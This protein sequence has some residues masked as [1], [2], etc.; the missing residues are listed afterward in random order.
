M[1]MHA[2]IPPSK[3]FVALL[4]TNLSRR[5]RLN[6]VD[7]LNVTASTARTSCERLAVWNIT[8]C[9]EDYGFVVKNGGDVYHIRCRG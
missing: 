7:S 2:K 5:F 1:N 3:N 4:I 6:V 9:T 8:T